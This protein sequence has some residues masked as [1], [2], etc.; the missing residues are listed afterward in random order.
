MHNSGNLIMASSPNMAKYGKGLFHAWTVMWEPRAPSYARAWQYGAGLRVPDPRLRPIS[1][2]PKDLYSITKEITITP[3]DGRLV[4]ALYQPP[5]YSDVIKT[6]AKHCYY[7]Y[8][9]VCNGYN[10]CVSLSPYI[11]IFSPAVP[12]REE[13]K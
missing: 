4:I 7:S 6:N 12:L 5:H 8:T 11:Q 3:G 1:T 13:R 9:F 2:D 10:Q